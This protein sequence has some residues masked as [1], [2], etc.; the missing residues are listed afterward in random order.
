MWYEDA[1]GVFRIIPEPMSSNTSALTGWFSCSMSLEE[2][3]SQ[4][5]S[6]DVYN[7]AS[8][9]YTDKLLYIT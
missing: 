9:N 5:F 8:N 6:A 1:D 7:A 2:H 4:S 3:L